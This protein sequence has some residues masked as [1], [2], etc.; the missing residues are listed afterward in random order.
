LFCVIFS[1]EANV[2]ELLKD[3]QLLF[4]STALSASSIG[5]L[6]Q[7][8]T[9]GKCANTIVACLLMVILISSACLFAAISLMKLKDLDFQLHEARFRNSSL[10]FAFC[11]AGLAYISFLLGR[12]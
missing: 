5:S 8:G 7:N 6:W 10:G 11:A 1:V 3:G 12:P 9:S 2:T 4:Y